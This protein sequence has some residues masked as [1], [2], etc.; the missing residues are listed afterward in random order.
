MFH[1]VE[2]VGEPRAALALDELTT[3][4]E[5]VADGGDWSIRQ[6]GRRLARV[7]FEDVRISVSWKA[8]V[9]ADPRE[10]Q[11]ADAHQDDLALDR[12]WERFGADLRRRGRA[13]DPGPDPLAN[14][15]FIAA[16]AEVYARTPERLPCAENFG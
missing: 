16:L 9:F 1:R 3:A 4:A 15:R 13:V 12:V 2:R 6:H 8:E 11:V 14:T 5:L 10:A 7:P